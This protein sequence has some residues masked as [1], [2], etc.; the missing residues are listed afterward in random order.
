MEKPSKGFRT[1][2]NDVN[3]FYGFER[4]YSDMILITAEKKNSKFLGSESKIDERQINFF[5]D[6]E[7][8]LINA[9]QE[10]WVETF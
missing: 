9:W 1:L 10:S 8:T 2:H 3:I 6:D 4:Y 5:P 7:I